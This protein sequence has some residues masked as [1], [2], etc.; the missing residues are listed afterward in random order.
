MAQD[1]AGK[2][3]VGKVNV[4]ENMEL[5]VKFG[6]SAVPTLLVFKGGEV[7]ERI[8]GFKDKADLQTVLDSHA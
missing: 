2:S 5:A 6:I 8:Q 4:G 7:V 1:N 3:V